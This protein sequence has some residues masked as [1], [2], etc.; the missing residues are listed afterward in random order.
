MSELRKN[1]PIWHGARGW[2]A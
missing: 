2:A 1:V